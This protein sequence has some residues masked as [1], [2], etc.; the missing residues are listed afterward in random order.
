MI[1]RKKLFQ[2]KQFDENRFRIVFRRRTLIL[3]DTPTFCAL[4]RKYAVYYFMC[5]EILFYAE[6]AFGMTRIGS[7]CGKRHTS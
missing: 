6:N 1:K 2:A 4:V 3:V 7:I 5:L